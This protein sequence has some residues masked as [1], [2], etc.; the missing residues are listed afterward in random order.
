MASDNKDKIILITGINGYIAANIGLQ[1]LQ[2][3]YTVRG[4]SRSFAAQ[5]HLLSDA[6]KG[7]ESQYQHAEVKDIIIDGA[8]DEAVKG[9]HSIIHTASPVDFNLTSVD[10][11]YIPAVRGNLSILNSA[12]SKAGPQLKSFVLTSS[13]AA[14]SDR[15]KQPVD[16]AYT[17]DDW[18][19]SAEAVA[20]ADF[21]APVAYGASKAGAER[22]MW[23]WQR[24]Y[25]PSFACA[26]INPGVVTGP[27]VTW[28]D[29]PDKLNTTL[30]PVWRIYSG[31][32]KTMPPQIGGATYIDVRDVAAMHVFAALN[33]QKSA[34]QRYLATNGKGPPQAIADLLRAKFPER[35]IIEGEPGQGYLKG[36]YWY[37][38]GESSAVAT[39]AYKA[40]EVDR[41]ITFDQSI[42]D[43]VEAFET[44]WP[45]LAKN[46]K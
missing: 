36:S 24:E 42:L 37:P 12:N 46:F 6:F 19:T 44:R 7:Y 21:T 26:A 22:A 1:L 28:P 10:A 17:E 3:G 31:E 11:F 14:I 4:T 40:M 8:F 30:L 32:A 2:K 43:T 33:P 16:H 35:D 38:E 25:Q 34:G 13:I 20:R 29:T 45:G 23:D 9:V 41:F 15:W 18:N 5:D 27:P 39:K